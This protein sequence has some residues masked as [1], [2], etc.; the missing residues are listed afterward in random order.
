MKVATIGF[1]G[2]P[3]SAVSRAQKTGPGARGHGNIGVA[4]L[5]KAASLGSFEKP[6][7][8][9]G[10]AGRG[11]GGGSTM[12]THHAAADGLTESSRAVQRR[13]TLLLGRQC[14]ILAQLNQ[15]ELSSGSKPDQAK[16]EL[17][18]QAAPV[19]VHV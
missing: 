2:K 11:R 7:S 15:L 12:A 10:P 19:Y 4:E 3:C 16:G 18:W 9:A 13:A 14:A 1:S 6:C 5:R 8:A 17:V